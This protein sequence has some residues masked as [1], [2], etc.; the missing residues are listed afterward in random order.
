M[1]ANLRRFNS[2]PRTIQTIKKTE[3]VDI[4]EN[5]FIKYVLEN[6]FN[7]ASTVRHMLEGNH[8]KVYYEALNLEEKLG[9][10]LNQSLLQGY[11]SSYN[12][13]IK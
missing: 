4:P 3:T 11:F 7:F 5:R 8:P 6:F 13:S 2:L 9:A 12:S 10:I 1:M